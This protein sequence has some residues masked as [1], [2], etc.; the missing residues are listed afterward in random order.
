MTDDGEQNGVF[1][2]ITN[3]DIWNE[4]QDIK[5]VI[6]TV[7]EDHKKVRSLELRIYWI[8]AGLTSAFI[9]I[10]YAFLGGKANG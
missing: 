7:P 3:R 1:V 8:L 9:A 10:G 5:K 6:S 4:L 2:R